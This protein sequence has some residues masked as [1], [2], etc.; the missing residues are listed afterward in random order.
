MNAKQRKQ[1]RQAQ[2]AEG[3]RFVRGV[4]AVRATLAREGDRWAW[5]ST[6]PHCGEPHSHDAGA[7]A[8]PPIVAPGI[9]ACLSRPYFVLPICLSRPRC[10]GCPAD[11]PGRN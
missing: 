10:A 7:S 6:C 3:V 1:Q 9:S 2:P 8:A 5:V 4:P 11:A